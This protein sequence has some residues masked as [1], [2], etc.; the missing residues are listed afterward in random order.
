MTTNA[1]ELRYARAAHA[2]LNHPSQVTRGSNGH[3]RNGHVAI[4]VG[5]LERHFS[6][7]GGTVLAVCGL[8]RGSLSGLALAALGGALIWRGHTGHCST[9]QMLRYSSA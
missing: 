8:L 1:G 2:K 7:V 9:Y 5:E 6:M 3:E 4:N